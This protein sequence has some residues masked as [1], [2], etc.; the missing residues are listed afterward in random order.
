MLF[1][2]NPL[3][4]KVKDYVYCYWLGTVYNY[5][6]YLQ[7]GLSLLNRFSLHHIQNLHHRTSLQLRKIMYPVQHRINSTYCLTILKTNWLHHK[8]VCRT[9]RH[10]LHS[11]RFKQHITILI[12]LQT[13]IGRNIPMTLSYK[14]RPFIHLETDVIQ[15]FKI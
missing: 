10:S 3:T 8:F 6:F 4:H 15:M 11:N 7:Q 14:P 2:K 9:W 13:K 12:H 5:F 1:C